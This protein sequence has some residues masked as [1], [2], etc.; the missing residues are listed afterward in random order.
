MVGVWLTCPACFGLIAPAS[1]VIGSR[2]A[3]TQY[4]P[5]FP[6]TPPPVSSKAVM[7]VSLFARIAAVTNREDLFLPIQWASERRL[8]WNLY[9][10][11]RGGYLNR[12]G[13]HCSAL[14]ARQGKRHLT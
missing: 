4:I 5:A 9:R 10:G 3:I 7:A 2:S 13:A 14:A 8:R 11:Q 1:M 6:I 12:C